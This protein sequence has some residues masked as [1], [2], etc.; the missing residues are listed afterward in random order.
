[1]T[2]RDKEKFEENAEKVLDLRRKIYSE[3]AK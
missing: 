3:N 1:M 2:H